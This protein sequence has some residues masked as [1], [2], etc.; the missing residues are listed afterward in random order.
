MSRCRCRAIR[1]K[2]IFVMSIDDCSLQVEEG[3]GGWRLPVAVPT[4]SFCLTLRRRRLCDSWRRLSDHSFCGQEFY[5][6]SV[7]CL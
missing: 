4:V 3:G 7:C 6:A 2:W 1:R 5:M